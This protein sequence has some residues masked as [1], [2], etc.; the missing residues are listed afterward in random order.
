MVPVSPRPT[1]QPWMTSVAI[2]AALLL[3]LMGWAVRNEN[4]VPETPDTLLIDLAVSSLPGDTQRATQDAPRPGIARD[5]A[6]PGTSQPE[7]N[8]PSRVEPA[9][10]NDPGQ[11]R[12]VTQ[13]DTGTLPTGNR[14]G[15]P[16]G[17]QT[18]E[19]DRRADLDRALQERRERE[20]QAGKDVPD[21]A[22]D[23]LPVGPDG[24]S[25]EPAGQQAGGLSGDGSG[26]T[27]E[28]SGRAVLD[29]P[30]PEYPE[31]YLREGIEGRVVLR[32]RVTPDGRV[33]SAEI[34]RSSERRLLD[35]S[36]RE[37][38]LRY[39]F[40]PLPSQVRQVTQSGELPIIFTL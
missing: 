19:G 5:T 31:E 23:P 12:A 39:R 27:G 4:P 20:R 10:V 30:S 29:R 9:T 18:T 1:W 15:K 37:A 13:A 34:V 24:D 36:A 3:L 21:L 25:L 22:G 16:A 14:D 32:L 26:L 11:A 35:R 6:A 33:E 38:A 40:A 17:G 2:H 8:D 7:V 28:L